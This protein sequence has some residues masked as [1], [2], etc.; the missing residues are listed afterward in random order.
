MKITVEY[1]HYQNLTAGGWLKLQTT[2]TEAGDQEP[3][4][5]VIANVQSYDLYDLAKQL[6]SLAYNAD[7]EEGKRNSIRREQQEGEQS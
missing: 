1:E 6:Q 7:D 2:K 5:F 4:S 3:V